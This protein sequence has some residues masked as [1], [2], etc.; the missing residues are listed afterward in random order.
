MRQNDGS[1]RIA[2]SI[3]RQLGVVAAL[4][5]GPVGIPEATAVLCGGNGELIRALALGLAILSAMIVVRAVFRAA[6][7]A[8]GSMTDSMTSLVAGVLPGLYLVWL[9]IAGSD[10][11]GCLFD[12]RIQ[13]LFDSFMAIGI[14]IANAIGY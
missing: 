1:G 12:R 6:R 10:V 4:P 3:D 9:A 11:A 14:T 8:T 2:Q 5:I 13:Q 7:N